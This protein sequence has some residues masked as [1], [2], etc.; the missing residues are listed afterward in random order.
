MT[1]VLQQADIIAQTESCPECGSRFPFIDHQTAEAVCTECGRVLLSNIEAEYFADH[2]RTGHADRD[3]VGTKHVSFGRHT[4][5]S[6]DKGSDE[7]DWHVLV[8]TF[9]DNPDK[10]FPTCLFHFVHDMIRVLY[11]VHK[12][13]GRE[14]ECV[15]AALFWH[16]ALQKNIKK[17][18][19]KTYAFWCGVT[20]E[21]WRA[22]RARRAFDLVR[23]VFDC[24][25]ACTDM[26]K[27][28]T[29]DLVALTGLLC[30]VEVHCTEQQMVHALSHA[31]VL[32]QKRN[33]LLELGD[34]HSPLVLA[35]LCIAKAMAWSFAQASQYTGVSK[36]LTP[37]DV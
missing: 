8:D 6:Y 4:F 32:Q 25:K 9:V 17:H 35:T 13:Y 33:K 27:E 28:W 29:D 20:E 36:T 1:S 18:G 22:G 15:L 5:S 19:F 26:K 2:E 16:A 3:D 34:G 21:S 7:K 24:Y 31:I 11:T 37:S 12:F 30:A 10:P 23:T 14:K